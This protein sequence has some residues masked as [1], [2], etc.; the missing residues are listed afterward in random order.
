MAWKNKLRKKLAKY[1]C[2]RV[3]HFTDVDNLPLIRSNGGLYSL[4]QL[5][6]RGITP[7]KPG[8][9]DWSHDADESRGLHRFVHLCFKESHPMEYVARSEGRIGPTKF[10]RVNIDVLFLD[11][12][13]YAPDVSNKSGVASVPL[14]DAVDEI[15]LEILF[16]RMDWKDPE[17]QARLQQAEKAE[18][19][20][21]DF[22]DVKLIGNL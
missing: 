22:V 8:G 1:G 15:D 4:E 2:Q 6:R 12:V 9:N 20:I 14:C 11:G 21:P 16:T 13:L 18:I 19:L 17:I 10:L 7:P 3:Y 5:K